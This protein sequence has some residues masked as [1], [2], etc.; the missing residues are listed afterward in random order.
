[1]RRGRSLIIVLLTLCIS[2][3]VVTASPWEKNWGKNPVVGREDYGREYNDTMDSSVAKNNN[4]N[5]VNIRPPVNQVPGVVNPVKSFNPVKNADIRFSK[6]REKF[7]ETKNRIDELREKAKERKEMFR[8]WKN[9]LESWINMAKRW[10][11]KVQVRVETMNI[12]SEQRVRIMEKLQNVEERLDEIEEKINESQNYEELRETVKELKGLWIELRYE[13]RI[14]VHEY[15]IEKYSVLF[16]RLKQV[17]DKLE[18]AGADVSELDEIIEEIESAVDDLQNY[19]GTP[20]FPEKVRE[21]NSMFREAFQLVK[22]IARTIN[23][24]Y[25][26][27]FVYAKVEGTFILSGNFT[28]VLIR[29][30]GNVS[31][32]DNVIITYVETNGKKK[33]VAR[34]NFTASGDGEFRIVAHGTGELKL[35]GEGY[36]RVKISPTEPVGEETEFEGSEV[37]EFGVVR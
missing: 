25:H 24:G 7:N 17:R 11:E 32:P 5:V 8:A 22:S 26:T 34:G 20:E 13:M 23:L 6:A 18:S 4:N 31:I 12:G 14:A 10:V 3:T 1:M 2:I 36:Y 29:G 9:H 33:I 15:A 16:E 19:I 30:E 28:S 37:I 35:D 21:V 27:G